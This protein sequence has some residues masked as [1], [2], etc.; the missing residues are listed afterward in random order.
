MLVETARGFARAI[1]GAIPHAQK[2]V[3]QVVRSP[4]TSSGRT[5]N[6]LT[7]RLSNTVR[8]EVLEP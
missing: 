7:S 3:S 1:A 4:S 2:T 6:C 5:D 8:G